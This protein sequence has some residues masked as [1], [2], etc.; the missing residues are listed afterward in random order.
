MQFAAFPI[1]RITVYAA[2][3]IAG[4]IPFSIRFIA[5]TSTTEAAMFTPAGIPFVKS[6]AIIRFRMF[7]RRNR[8][9]HRRL[10]R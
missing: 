3:P 8:N 7:R 4:S 6:A 2:T 5:N 1:D 9:T 10:N